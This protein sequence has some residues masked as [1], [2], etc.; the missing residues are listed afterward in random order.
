MRAAAAFALGCSVATATIEQI[1][2]WANGKAA[3]SPCAAHID[4]L[5]VF[6]LL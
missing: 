4:F 3:S 6:T 5:R 1:R 2:E